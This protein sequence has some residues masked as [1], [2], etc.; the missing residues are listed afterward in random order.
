MKA[1]RPVAAFAAAILVTLGAGG[2]APVQVQA[3]SVSEARQGGA[4][5]VE[6]TGFCT[7]GFNEAG[8]QRSFTAA[9][10]GEEG[11]RVHLLDLNTG[12][13][14]GA[15]GT[16]FRSKVYDEHLGNDWAAIQWDNGVRIAPNYFSGD[17][18]VNPGSIR[19]GERVCYYGQITNRR[20]S[21]PTCGTF[22]GAVGNTYFVDARLTQP[23]DSGG[24]M[25][26][27]GRGFVGVVSSMWTAAP[28]PLIGKRDFIIGV[29]PVDGPGVSETNL[30]ALYVQNL[31]LV[32]TGSSRG[33]GADLIRGAFAQFMSIFN[34][35]G[36]RIPGLIN[37]S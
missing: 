24:P 30:F 17:A 11:A 20:T 35:L 9:H 34:S 33:P 18:W 6:G 29:H 28:L 10:C 4:I 22:E 3:Q 8:R 16:F 13:Q 25:W 12:T 37:Y 26:V 19:P 7:I 32:A 14:S 15:V 21:E 27:P 5:Y 36:L 2:L 31:L 1:F 23:G